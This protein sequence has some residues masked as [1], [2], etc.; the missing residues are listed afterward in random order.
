MK[1]CCFTGHR[2]L[3]DSISKILRY[4]LYNVIEEL[5]K[6][7]FNIF[8][9]GGALGFDTIAAE[10]VLKLKIQY[11]NIKLVLMLP[12]KNRTKSWD[13]EDI[14]RYEAIKLQADDVIYISEKYTRGCMHLRNRRLAEESSICVAYCTRSTGGS[15]YTVKYAYQQQLKVILLKGK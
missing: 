4:E 8:R 3:S 6:E 13:Q 9:T 10:T 1:I 11:P 2:I 12:C 7:G 14:M 15:V 5:I